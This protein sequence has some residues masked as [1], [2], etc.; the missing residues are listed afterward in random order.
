MSI[1][2]KLID[3]I[4]HVDKYL[5]LVVSQYGIL[6][7]LILFIV[8]FCETGL[9]FT[10]FLPGDS[11]L[12][13]SGTFAA[14][15]ALNVFL[16]WIVFALAAILGDSANYFIGSFFGEKVFTKI[17]FFRQDYLDKTKKFYE[18]YGVKTIIIARFVPIVRTFAPFVAGV[19]KMDYKKF[20]LYNIIGGLLWVTLILFA[21]FYFGKIDWVEKNLTLITYLIIVISILPVIIEVVRSKFM[22]S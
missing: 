19:G 20:F 17:K 14:N 11:L 12:F 18:K 2:T 10:P 4:L 1:V 8:V 5:S 9:V 6:T 16:L 13:I 3:F 21:G 22:K 7:Y 15:G